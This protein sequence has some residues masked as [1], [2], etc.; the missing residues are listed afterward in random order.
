MADAGLRL[1]GEQ[2]AG[3]G[4]EEAHHRVVLP[5][6]GVGDVDD[7]GGAGERRVEAFAGERVDA[8]V[9]GRRDRLV[10]VLAELGD[11]LRADQSGAADDHDLHEVPFRSVPPPGLSSRAF[12]DSVTS[13]AAAQSWRRMSLTL[14]TRMAARATDE[15]NR[16][17][18]QLELLFDLT[19]VI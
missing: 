12:R 14:H 11:E 7:H 3:R 16:V 2:V 19:F 9:G 10:P 5:R 1:G 18:S 8:G 6:G 17:S 15:P 13:G 4:L